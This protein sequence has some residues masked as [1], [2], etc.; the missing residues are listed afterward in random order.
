MHYMLN[1]AQKLV[2]LREHVIL[3]EAA[4]ETDLEDGVEEYMDKKDGSTTEER[5]VGVNPDIYISITNTDD[6][7]DPL[8][9]IKGAE[10]GCMTMR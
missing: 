9:N 10:P 6:D 5:Q 2:E 4:E 7:T 8:T 3:M 1:G